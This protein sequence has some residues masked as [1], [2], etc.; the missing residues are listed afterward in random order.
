MTEQEQNLL[1]QIAA[2]KPQFEV[3]QKF[4]SEPLEPQNLELSLDLSNEEYGERSK[5]AAKALKSLTE[6]FTEMERMVEKKEA[7]DQINPAR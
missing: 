6:R 3:L 1:K 7:K 4:L 5:V 2:N